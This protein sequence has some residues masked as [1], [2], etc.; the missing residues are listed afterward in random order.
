MFALSDR[1]EDDG[2]GGIPEIGDSVGCTLTVLDMIM[3]KFLFL[4][5]DNHERQRYWTIMLKIY[6]KAPEIFSCNMYPFT[7]ENTSDR[8]E[9]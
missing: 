4:S 1:K 5:N 3:Y 9:R 7:F 2:I 8:N 6:E